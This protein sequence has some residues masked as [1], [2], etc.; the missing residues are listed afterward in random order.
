[1][2]SDIQQI[3]IFTVSKNLINTSTTQV[4]TYA[5]EEIIQRQ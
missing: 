2:D 1:M 4:I 3:S 5:S